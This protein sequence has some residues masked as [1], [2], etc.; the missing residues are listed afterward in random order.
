MSLKRDL[1]LAIQEVFTAEEWVKDDRNEARNKELALK[2]ATVDKDQKN[3]EASLRTA[4]ADYCLEIWIE[5][6][7]MAPLPPTL[8]PEATKGLG[9][10]SDH[11]HGVEV[12]K[13]KE[14]AQSRARP[15]DKGKGKEAAPKAKESEP[16]KPQTVA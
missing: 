3:K 7:N 11:G 16:A 4:E 9:K 8:P 12:A 6:L 14:V 5:A 1:A 10:A 2:L 15:E 13:G